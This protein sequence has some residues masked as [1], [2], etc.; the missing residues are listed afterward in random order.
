[1]Q[2]ELVD[3]GYAMVLVDDGSGTGNKVAKYFVDSDGN[4][5]ELYSYVLFSPVTGVLETASF[6]LKVTL[7]SPANP[8]TTPPTPETPNSVNPQDLV[9]QIN[10]LSN[11]IYA[12]FGASSPGQAPAFLPIQATG[13]GEVQAG[14]IMGSPGFNG[15][16]LNVLGANRQPVQISQIYSGPTIFPLAGTSTVVPLNAKG[17]PVAFYGSI[18]HGLDK[19]V[20][21]RRCTAPDLSSQIPRPTSPQTVTSGLFGGSGLGALIGTPLSF[22]F[23]GSGAIPPQ[24]A[25]DPTPGTTMKA[26][27]SVFYSVNA[28]ANTT[29]DSTGKAGT[30]AGG[31]YFV[32]TTDPTQPIYGVVAL[33]KFTF[34][35]NTYSVNLTTTLSDGVTSRYTLVA[36]GQSYLFGPDNAHVTVNDTVFTFNPIS[37]GTYSVTYAAADA[38]AGAEAPSPIALTP[39]S[40]VCGGA[41]ETVDVFNNPGG[42]LDMVLGV[43]GR[44][45]SYNPVAG[46]VVVSE[47]A[48]ETTSATQTGLVY[49]VRV[50]LRLRDRRERGRL[51]GERRPDVPVA[52]FDDRNSDVVPAR[53]S[54]ADVH[55][56]RR[57]L[58]LRYHGEWHL[59]H[60]HR[61]GPSGADQSVSVLL[62]RPDLCHR[63]QRD[64]EHRD[65]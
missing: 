8:N 22:A 43:T 3:Q 46:T 39:F 29:M 42:L 25:S 17:K 7:G 36:G 53:D 59:R 35:T 27:D 37:G 1:M 12:A 21:S 65:R 45:Y 58:H 13:T 52:R 6:P 31:Q 23:Q 28:L 18:S 61:G 41:I 15:Y 14:T 60:R 49:R 10:T 64:A 40:V 26:D 62:E 44:L 63:H 50:Q 33:P 32:D 19:Q 48:T 55:A 38:P 57:L 51:H 34:N 5:F 11:L 47:G 30:L 56:W 16:A 9:A 2:F 54:A 4:Y 24:I 20:R